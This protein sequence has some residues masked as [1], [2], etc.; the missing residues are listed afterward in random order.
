[1]TYTDKHIVETYSELLS[2][3]SNESKRGLIEALS[4]SMEKE[5]KDKKRAF[6]GS[7]GAFSSDKTA[8]DI[9]AELRASRSFRKK[10]L[11]F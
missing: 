8:E 1:M 10:D 7:F 3:L 11:E 9:I 4:K 2:G 6:F 5:Q